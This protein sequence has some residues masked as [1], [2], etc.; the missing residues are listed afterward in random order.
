MAFLVPLNPASRESNAVARPLGKASA[1][2]VR[3]GPYS[4]GEPAR[5]AAAE[6]RKTGGPA[7]NDKEELNILNEEMPEGNDQVCR[8]GESIILP[9]DLATS[10]SR[11]KGGGRGYRRRD[12]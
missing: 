9:G 12:K 1:E 2:E 7:Y 3:C 10:E 11:H 4:P 6:A 8:R 5:Q